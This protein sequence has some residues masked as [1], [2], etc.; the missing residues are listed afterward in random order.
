MAVKIPKTKKMNRT[1]TRYSKRLDLKKYNGEITH[2]EFE[3]KKLRLADR[4]D[5][6][7]DFLVTMPDGAMQCHEVKGGHVRDDARVKFKC[8]SG[9]FSDFV[10]VWAQWVEKTRLWKMEKWL[11]GECVERWKE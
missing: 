7:P 9:M 8:A 6:T 2:W 1:E 11:G 5:Y 10:F 4:C 3:G